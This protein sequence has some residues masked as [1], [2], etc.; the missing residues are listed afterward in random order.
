M[1]YLFEGSRNSGKT[2]LSDHISKTF[3]VPKFKFDF[4]SY[5]KGLNLVSENSRETHFFA[6]GKE[7][8]LMQISRDL[9]IPDFILDRGIIT[10]FSWALLEKRISEE[11]VR[12]QVK[13]ICENNLLDEICIV[14]IEGNNPDKSPRN[15]DN[16]DHLDFNS[17][18]KK[19]CDFVINEFESNGFKIF[20][21][22][23]N[24]TEKDKENIEF[25]FKSF[26]F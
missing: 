14:Y 24:F 6:M 11:E 4:V 26:K 21:F 22:R 2:F 17:E 23:N 15:K 16:W 1:I 19:F 20:Y 8:M 18:E 3:N 7:L 9:G 13:L 12:S 5:F 25:I 10:V